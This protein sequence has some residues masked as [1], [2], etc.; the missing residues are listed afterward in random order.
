MLLTD[1]SS[2]FANLEAVVG[3]GSRLVP[4]A[5]LQGVSGI[6]PPKRYHTTNLVSVPKLANDEQLFPLDESL[7]QGSLQSL[8]GFVLVSIVAGRVEHSEASLDGL[9]HGVGAHIVGNLPQAL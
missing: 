9:V 4:V 5:E 7:V 1:Q 8:A 2:R 6:L 3:F